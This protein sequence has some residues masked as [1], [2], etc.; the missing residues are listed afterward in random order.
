MTLRLVRP[1]EQ[2]EDKLELSDQLLIPD[3][4]ELPNWMR[5]L[6]KDGNFSAN[7]IVQMWDSGNA[8]DRKIAYFRTMKNTK[9][10]KSQE[11]AKAFFIKVRRSAFPRFI[12]DLSSNTPPSL[13]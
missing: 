9:E 10:A 5:E 13:K 11:E 4:W 8:R 1:D 12:K 6:A 2:P 3:G 7:N